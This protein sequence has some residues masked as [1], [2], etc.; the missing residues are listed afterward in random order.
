MT[1]LRGAWRAS[2]ACFVVAAATGALFRFQLAHGW[3]T[4]LDLVHVRH[5]HSH[6]MYFG[7][8]TPALVALM[9]ARSQRLW[10]RAP[11]PRLRGLLIAVFVAS[12][13]SWLLFLLFGY[14]ST[15]VGSARLPPAMIVAGVHVVLWYWLAALSWRSMRGAP[16]T[17]AV[18]AWKSA[19][20][21]LVLATLGAWGLTAMIPLGIEKP[22][23]QTALVHLFLDLFSEGWFVLAV[24]GLAWAELAPEARGWHWS[25]LM[26]VLG[27][28]FGF[29]LSLP[30][31]A[32]P[33]GLRVVVSIGGVTAGAGLAVQ[34][35]LLWKR[36]PS[37]HWKVPLA[38]LALVGLG[39]LAVAAVPS[40][41]WPTLMG[42]R[43]LYLHVLLLGFVTLGLLAAATGA[44]PRERIPS[45]WVAAS[46]LLVIASL[47]PLSVL[48]PSG[49]P[50]GWA[51]E[52][53][54]WVALGPILAVGAA[55][56]ISSRAPTL[57]GDRTKG[58]TE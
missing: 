56:F 38:A 13:A 53:A 20:L 47:L 27:T 17:R 44:F 52:A 28:P 10:Q 43:I 40:I 36:A 11:A 8:V 26:V 57:P 5:A 39:R 46:A 29:L 50:R 12:V 4:G 41:A 33:P 24:L 25:L 3:Q 49:L 34:S 21:F 7:W 30:V 54:A 19:W 35:V 32:L 31:D 16:R 55:L 2:L 51:F 37:W 22:I 6:L 58:R 48:W 45:R 23:L 9:A 1:M 14:E 42:L 18:V 15:E